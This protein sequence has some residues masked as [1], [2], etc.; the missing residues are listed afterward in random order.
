MDDGDD[1]FLPLGGLRHALFL[2]QVRTVEELARM[3]DVDLLRINGIRPA[4][5]AP[6]RAFL[7]EHGHDLAR[8]DDRVADDPARDL[9][10]RR[11]DAPPIFRP[12]SPSRPTKRNEGVVGPEGF[13]PP[14]KPL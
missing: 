9:R 5:L 1:P 10:R 6:I 4:H 3:S 13:E 8:R 7:A 11:A 12:S 2:A 14:T